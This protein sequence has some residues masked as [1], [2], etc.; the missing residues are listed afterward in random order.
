MARGVKG[1][2]PPNDMILATAAQ[3]RSI[4]SL[5]RRLAKSEP[6]FRKHCDREGILDA[7][8][9]ALAGEIIEIAEAEPVPVT[10]PARVKAEQAAATISALRRE[11]NDYAK[12]L[13]SQ[14][15][16]FDR[17]VEA[18]R[19]PVDTPKYKTV[20]QD[21]RK[22]ARSA[23]LPIY[24]Q[25]FGQ[26]VR[27]SDTPGN[28]GEFSVEVFD[29]RL[30][31][32]V[33]AV[34]TILSDQAGA[35]RFEELL[36]PFGGDQVEGDEIFPGQ[37]WQLELDPPR[38]VWELASKMDSA[39]R[40][41]VKFAR[42]EL[43]VKFLG[44]YGVTGNHGKVGGKKSGA[45]PATYSWDWL[46]LMIL[47]DRLRKEKVDEFAIEPGGSLFFRCAGHEFQAIHGDQ[48]KGWGGLP[49]YGLT[50]FD[51]RSIRLHN[52]IYR[53]LLM[54]HHHQPAAIPNGAGE[55]IVSGDWVG[56]NN[57]SGMITAASRPR[58][59][60]LFVSRRWGLAGSE[61]VWFT[62]ADEAYAPAHVYGAAA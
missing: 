54:G 42:T 11:N 33:D 22:H 5:A 20:K 10:D 30:A 2:W 6:T 47:F 60:V 45:R 12:A 58:Q 48:I 56:A 61:R 21:G 15:Q 32:W 40:E 18:T 46:F 41:V 28:R 9:Q 37:A 51:G 19:V 7:V 27:A 4:T 26:F 55:T 62:E 13:A 34:C 43:G 17:I 3:E 23:I 25:Q 49:F 24:D 57:L 14:E 31:R 8:K 38:Q 59:E 36:I 39:I 53:Y 52:R 29:R 50:K 35:Y 44:L 1:V 16:F